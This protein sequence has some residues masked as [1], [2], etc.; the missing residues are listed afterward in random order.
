M[1]SWNSV[2]TRLAEVFKAVN[3]ES[4]DNED[5]VTAQVSSKCGN[6]APGQTPRYEVASSTDVVTSLAAWSSVQCQLSDIFSEAL[7]EEMKLEAKV[8]DMIFAASFDSSTS[9]GTASVAELSD[10]SDGEFGDDESDEPVTP[11][12]VR[13]P[14]ARHRSSEN[15]STDCSGLPMHDIDVQ[16]W[17]SVGQ[18]LSQA[19]SSIEFSDDEDYP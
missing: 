6:N 7:R 19:L 4:C 10:I 3:D 12:Q 11:C 15:Q 14:R 9:E 1:R 18:R 2:S 5:E 17:H 8:S 16:A 13:E